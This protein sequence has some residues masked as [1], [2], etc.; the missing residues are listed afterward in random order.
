MIC[1]EDEVG[2][3]SSHAGIMVLPSDTPVG[4]PAS[5]YFNIEEDVVFEIDLTP[6]RIDAASH[7]GVARDLAAFRNIKYNIPDVSKF[8]VSKTLIQL[9]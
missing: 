4:L 2:I 1:A 8:K 3:G 9:I 5:E 6:N 7:I